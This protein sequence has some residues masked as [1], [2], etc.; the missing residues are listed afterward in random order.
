MIRHST[1]SFIDEN[2]NGIF[3]HKVDL[4][5]IHDLELDETELNEY[6]L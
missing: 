4:D 1:L 6:P 2:H 3:L 5:P